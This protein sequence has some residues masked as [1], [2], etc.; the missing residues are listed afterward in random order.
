MQ[1]RTDIGMILE[2]SKGHGRPG[3]IH[4]TCE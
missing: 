2:Y 4:S 3:M 1:D